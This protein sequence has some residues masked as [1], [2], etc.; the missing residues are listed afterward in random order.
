[1]APPR[2]PL[3]PAT[4]RGPAPPPAVTD[5]TPYICGTTTSLTTCADSSSCAT[6]SFCDTGATACCTLGNGGTINVDGATGKDT[7]ACCGIGTNGACQTLTHAMA[8]IDAAQAQNVTINA[9]VNG[10]G[11]DW[12][13]NETYPVVLGWG[14]EISA[15]GVFFA[16]L[17]GP[18]GGFHAQIFDINFYSASDTIGYASLV[19]SASAAVG[20]GMDSTGN[21]TDD[22]STITVEDKNALYVANASVNGSI[23][24]PD[25]YLT[26]HLL[27]GA[28]LIL[29]QDQSGGSP[30]PSRSATPSAKRPPMARPGS[31]ARP[32]EPV[33]A[34]L[35]MPHS[36]AKAASSSRARRT[37]TF[38]SRTTRPSRS[39]R[40]RSSAC[41]P[42]LR[43]LA[44]ARER[45]T[46]VFTE[47]NASQ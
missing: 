9:T 3:G 10:A 23:D 13:A 27:D 28:K 17:M 8:L 35:R 19:G 34:R 44:S 30:V 21:Q 11:G 18:K 38:T 14:V 25:A 4:T 26:F 31:N 16:D 47:T 15:P 39:P 32:R 43:A 40:I 2:P 1:L 46:P 36:W 12:T 29:G 24:N 41:P 7:T 22:T 5:C 6:G 45:A 37:G 42:V 20:V 33:P